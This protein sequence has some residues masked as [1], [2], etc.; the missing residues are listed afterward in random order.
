MRSA[1]PLRW[2]PTRPLGLCALLYLCAST[3]FLTLPSRAQEAQQ[4]SQQ[5]A[6]AARQEKARKAAQQKKESHVYTNEDLKQSQI[7]T[8]QDRSRV[9]ARKNNPAAAPGRPAEPSVNAEKKSAPESLGEAARRYRRQKLE[10]SQAAEAAKRPPQTRF[11][12]DFS[13]PSYAAPAKPVAPIVAPN[14]HP[15]LT[16]KPLPR[17]APSRRDPFSRQ[18]FSSPPRSERPLLSPNLSA[19]PRPAISLSDAAPHTPA[20]RASSP[21]DAPKSLLPGKPL[22]ATPS[23]APRAVPVAPVE[24]KISGTKQ[25]QVQPGDSLWRLAR[26]HL[27]N[28]SRWSE[29]LASNPGVSDPNRIQPGT[30]LVVPAPDLRPRV[31]PS[32]ITIRSGDSLWKLAASRLGSGAAWPCIAQANPQLRDPGLL[33]PGQLLVLPASCPLQLRP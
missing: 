32:S 7:L 22:T 13:Q 29:L 21:A 9:E 10:N 24:N 6:E 25:I 8:E 16:V 19:P 31:Q 2:A 15:R 33:R 12:M 1:H 17:I 5:L 30:V 20:S 27:G 11:P 26:R 23:L 28:G 4:N 14:S 18:S 3:S